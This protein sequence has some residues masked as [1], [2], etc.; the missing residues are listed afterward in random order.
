MTGHGWILAVLAQVIAFGTTLSIAIAF[1]QMGAPTWAAA[2]VALYVYIELMRS[3][4][5][6][7][8]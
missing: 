5:R 6:R 4:R 7:D 1:G 3:Y 2:A 8:H